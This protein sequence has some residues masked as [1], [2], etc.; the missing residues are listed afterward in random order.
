M[1]QGPFYTMHVIYEDQGSIYIPVPLELVSDFDSDDD[2]FVYITWKENDDGTYTL[3]PLD[4]DGAPLA[5]LV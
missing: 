2:K 5:N 4:A 1:R 3:I